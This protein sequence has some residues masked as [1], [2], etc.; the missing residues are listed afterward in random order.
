[1]QQLS[2]QCKKVILLGGWAGPHLSALG[3]QAGEL[4]DVGAE[5]VG[6][7]VQEGL[8]RGRQRVVD[9]GEQEVEDSLPLR[10]QA[11]AQLRDRGA[12]VQL[13]LRPAVAVSRTLVPTP[14]LSLV[15]SCSLQNGTNR[16]GF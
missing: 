10:L 4:P 1:M 16:V 13:V 6:L 15:E 7:D 12:G 14:L 2:T 5:G 9:G 11:L 8:L 3:Q